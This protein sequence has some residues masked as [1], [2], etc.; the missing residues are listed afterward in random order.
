[1]KKYITTT[2]IISSSSEI[3]NIKI[4]VFDN[5]NLAKD[6]FYD[7]V[8]SYSEEIVFIKATIIEEDHCVLNDNNEIYFATIKIKEDTTKIICHLIAIEID[9]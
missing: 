9:E 1:M 3:N 7:V 4:E 2:T 5:Y 6:I 8:A